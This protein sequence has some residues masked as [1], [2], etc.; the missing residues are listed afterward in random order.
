MDDMDSEFGGM[1]WGLPLRAIE[2]D[3]YGNIGRMVFFDESEIGP[4]QLSDFIST[5]QKQRFDAMR[6]LNVPKD[7]MTDEN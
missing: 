7:D 3:E 6:K 4:M 1:E 2:F 5:F